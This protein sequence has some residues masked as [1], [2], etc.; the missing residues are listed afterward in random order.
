MLILMSQRFKKSDSEAQNC[1]I[2]V[3]SQKRCKTVSISILQNSQREEFGVNVFIQ[4]TNIRN[5]YKHT[6][7]YER[8]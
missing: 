1:C 4:E 7:H 6:L 5:T 3:H 8:I 2:N